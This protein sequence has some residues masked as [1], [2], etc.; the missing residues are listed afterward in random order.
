MMR[1]GALAFLLGSS[2]V[3]CTTGDMKPDP[4]GMTCMTELSLQGSFTPDGTRPSGYDGCWGAG[5]WTFT[6]S[7][8]SNTCSSA[9]QLAPQYKF[10][11]ATMADMQGD[12]IVDVFTLQAPDPSTVMSLVKLTQLAATTCEGEVDICSADGK[13]VFQLRPDLTESAGTGISGQG[14]YLVYNTAN[15]PAM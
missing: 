8:S 6:A 11:A 5:T 3:A 9:P 14:E 1:F 2:L 12:P 13:Q 10:V 15:C 7:V 4:N